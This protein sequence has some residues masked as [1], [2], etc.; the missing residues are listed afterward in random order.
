VDL[1]IR[2]EQGGATIVSLSGEMDMYTS[3]RLRDSVTEQLAEGQNALIIDC[4]DLSYI[5]SSGI[6]AFLHTLARCRKVG[7]QVW[8][9]GVGGSVRRVIE[10]TSLLGFLP[11]V[12]SISEAAALA[13]EARR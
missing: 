6:G 2:R 7:A 1:R 12:E 4:S 11:I 9:V 13:S 10:L 8:F 5:D 3:H